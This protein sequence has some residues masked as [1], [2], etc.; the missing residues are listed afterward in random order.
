M[1]K[2]FTKENVVSMINS[3]KSILSKEFEN[4]KKEAEI[5][6]RESF[7]QTFHLTSAFQSLGG[8]RALQL[9]EAWLDVMEEK[10]SN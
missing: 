4:E 1:A 9:L 7:E 5:C 3:F 2:E 8:I 6:E 10:E